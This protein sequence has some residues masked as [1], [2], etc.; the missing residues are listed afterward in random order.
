MKRILS[1]IAMALAPLIAAA[2]AYPS[3]PIHVI[4]PFPPGG[5]S[6]IFARGLAQGMTAPLGQPV[7]V[8]N[9]GGQGGVIGVDRAVKSAPDGYTIGFNSG[10]TLAIAPYSF[11]KLPYD[12]KKDFALIT[13]VVRVPEVL[14]VHPSLP[15]KSLAELVAYAKANPGKVN[16]GSA[17]GGSI[18][19][20]AGELLKAEAK[21]DIVHVP[22]KGAAPAV[23][24]LLGGQVQMGIF[25]VPILLGHIRSGRLKALAI[26][27]ATR[28]PSLPDVATTAELGYPNVTSDNWYGLVVPA[29]TPAEVQH[30]LNAAAVAALKSPAVIEQFAKVGGVAS[31]GTQEDYAKFLAVEQAKWS[32]IVTAIGFKEE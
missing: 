29:A 8:E 24:D 3:K 7:V 9:V 21:I 19:H 31:P 5:P 32:K 10:S 6:D 16:F 17:G 14:A 15:V 18:T 2:Q 13:V 20:L 11:A 25:D 12:V 4:V 23:N 27:S 1:L 26:T 30:R 22:Y 28:A